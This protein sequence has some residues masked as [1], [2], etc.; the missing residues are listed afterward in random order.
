MALFY[1]LVV[2]VNVI[3][4]GKA[5]LCFFRMLC[6]LPCPG[7]GLTHSTIALLRGS[8]LESLSCCPFTVFMLATV[9]AGLICFFA[10]D[11][12]PRP[13]RGI[14]RFLA[15]NRY[16]HLALG[17][18]FFLLYIVRMVLYFPNGPYPMVYDSNNYLSLTYRVAIGILHAL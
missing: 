6:G 12:L 9:A 18:M 8:F 15:H 11:L 10:P 14:A 1:G 4:L 3:L 17:L 7:C 13:L 16:W 2:V 5:E